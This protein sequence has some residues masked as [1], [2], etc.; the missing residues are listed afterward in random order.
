[1]YDF[2]KRRNPKWV[3]VIGIILVAAMLV[4]SIVAGFMI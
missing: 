2:S 4:T 1:M 3:A